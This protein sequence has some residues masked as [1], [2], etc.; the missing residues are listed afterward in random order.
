MICHVYAFPKPLLTAK[1]AF[2]KVEQVSATDESKKGY[3]WVLEES[4]LIEGVKSTTRY[5]K[6]NPHKKPGK[7]EVPAPQ[8]Q[9]SG[10]KGG[11]AA[12]KAAKMKRST[13]MD[14]IKPCQFIERN[15]AGYGAA[16]IMEMHA[17]GTADISLT[18]DT[19]PYYLH[20]SASPA[21]SLV[22]EEN[23]YGYSNAAIGTSASADET[24]FYDTGN[25][26][27]LTCGPFYD[28]EGGFLK[29]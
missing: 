19:S 7:V 4:A 3:I 28:P 16:S 2:K 22:L 29:S 27:I 17:P 12:K 25:D 26:L 6:H 18:P 15:P 24:L 10:A 8:R 1:Q 14:E 21:E 13:R 20:T 23:P 11:K 5:R 9:R